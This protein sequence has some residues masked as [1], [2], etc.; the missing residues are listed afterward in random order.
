M[1]KKIIVN[2]LF[3]KII[4][5]T[6]NRGYSNKK[7]YSQNSSDIRR[8]T[9]SVEPPEGVIVTSPHS[10]PQYHHRHHKS[11]AQ[12][13]PNNIGASKNRTKHYVMSQGNS[14]LKQ[15]LE[16]AKRKG[17]GLRSLHRSDVNSLDRDNSS[18][19]ERFEQPLVSKE[20][21]IPS[22]V[23]SSHKRQKLISS[24]VDT[25][26]SQISKN[27][28]PQFIVHKNGKVRTSS[29][30]NNSRT[31]SK[32]DKKRATSSSTSQN[33]KYL[34]GTK[35]SSNNHDMSAKIENYAVQKYYDQLSQ[36]QHNKSAHPNVGNHNYSHI[37]YEIPQA[38]N[39]GLKIIEETSF[40]MKKALK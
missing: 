7:K 33:R 1:H 32:K 26:I 36:K 34:T 12:P 31:N 30:N 18:D 4:G 24:A 17:K 22:D 8:K 15:T 40:K 6:D 35:N 16:R 10:Q 9:N 14:E 23:Y 29:L 5:K 2:I 28:S 20:M 19:Y 38:Y 37:G 25:P 11:V 21:K 27:K 3:F 13:K 39:S